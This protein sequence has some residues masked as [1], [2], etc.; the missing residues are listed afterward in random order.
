MTG[1][2]ANEVLIFSIN[3]QSAVIGN[4]KAHPLLLVL[5]LVLVLRAHAWT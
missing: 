3:Y 4:I 1:R 5:V 2:A